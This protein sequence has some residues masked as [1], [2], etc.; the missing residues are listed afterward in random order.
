[1]N[2]KMTFA[3]LINALFST[4]APNSTGAGEVVVCRHDQRPLRVRLGR[5]LWSSRT[6]LASLSPAD[7]RRDNRVAALG[8]MLSASD[9]FRLFL[10]QFRRRRSRSRTQRRCGRVG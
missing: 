7:L 4:R 10:K 3:G 5:S 9:R 2:A 8:P 1:V 6:L